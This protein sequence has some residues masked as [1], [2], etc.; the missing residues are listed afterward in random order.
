MVTF[1]GDESGSGGSGNYIVSGYV[2]HKTTW[3]FFAREWNKALHAASP[4]RVDYLKMSEW[5]HRDPEKDTGQFIGWNDEDATLKLQHALSILCL[6][7]EQGSIGEFT[8]CVSW[9]DYNQRVNGECR[10]VFDNPYYFDLMLITKRA[11][12]FVKIKSPDFKGKINFVFDQGNPA[13]PK[14]PVH[15]QKIREFADPEIAK[16]IGPLSFANDKD[17][18]GLQAADASA[19]HTRR[20]LAGLDLPD[21]IRQ[22]HFRLLQECPRTF[23]RECIGGDGLSLFNDHVNCLI[24]NLNSANSGEI[25]TK[26]R[27]GYEDYE[28][29]NA[30]MDKILKVPPNV[31]KMAMEVDKQERKKQRKAKEKEEQG[32]K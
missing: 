31:V 15:F 22:R 21:D 28:T 12:E 7:L 3:D 1:Y 24:D 32:G 10:K 2:A 30:A 23:S 13:E 20:H 18:P 25:M 9:E 26:S 16:Y 29:F 17:E 6:F 5:Q 8:S 14:A 11:A 27:D 19:W 4:R